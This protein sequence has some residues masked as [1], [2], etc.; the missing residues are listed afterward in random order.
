VH[1]VEPAHPDVSGPKHVRG[2]SALSI[3]EVA[4]SREI[5]A[6]RAVERV[7]AKI[8]RVGVRYGDDRR[9]GPHDVSH[10]AHERRH[11]VSEVELGHE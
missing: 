6:T 11:D 3:E 1:I 7:G 4:L 8:P 2:D 10:A 5:A 9:V